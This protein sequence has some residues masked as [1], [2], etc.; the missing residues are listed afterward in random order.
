MTESAEPFRAT[1]HSTT[2]PLKGAGRA[3]IVEVSSFFLIL[4]LLLFLRSFSGDLIEKCSCACEYTHR[5]PF[6]KREL[7]RSLVRP[8]DVDFIS[9][10]SAVD[11]Q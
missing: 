8:Y 2:P 11:T 5:A 9:I 6:P 1:D 4:L 3:A 7:V 10:F